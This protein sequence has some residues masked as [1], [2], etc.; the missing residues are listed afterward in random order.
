VINDANKHAEHA[1]EFRSAFGQITLTIDGSTTFAGTVAP[2][3]AGAPGRPRQRGHTG[4]TTAG[5]RRRGGA[6]NAVNLNPVGQGGNYIPFGMLCD[7]GS[8]RSGQR[9]T[10]RDV[11]VRNNRLRTTSC[12]GGS[13]R[14]G[15]PGHLRR[16]YQGERRP[17][18]GQRRLRA[19]GGGNGAFVVRNPSRNAMPMLRTTFKAEPGRSTAHASTSRHAA[20]TRS[21]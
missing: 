20:S 3:P 21:S 19:G 10:F 12:S 4:R 6:P 11:I 8:R 15:L 9:A 13:G 16:R 2:A 14:R 17:V 1:I 18:G 5:R 7:I